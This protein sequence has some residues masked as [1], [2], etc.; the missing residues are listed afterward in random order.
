MID[1]GDLEKYMFTVKPPFQ[2]ENNKPEP[3]GQ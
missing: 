2:K 3:P 1:S